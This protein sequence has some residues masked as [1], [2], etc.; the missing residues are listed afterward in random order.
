[1]QAQPKITGNASPRQALW[2]P[3]GPLWGSFRKL[4]KYK[5]NPIWGLKGV[6]RF[7]FTEKQER[8]KAPSVYSY[9]ENTSNLKLS[10]SE[11][12]TKRLHFYD[13]QD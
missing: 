6:E 3:L 11:K 10:F 5:E 1:M 4:R 12:K 7:V 9:P 8:L 2:D 13:L